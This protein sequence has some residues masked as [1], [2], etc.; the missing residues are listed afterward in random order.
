MAVWAIGAD[1]TGVI[2]T[3]HSFDFSNNEKPVLNKSGEPQGF[4]FWGEKCDG[5]IEGLVPTTSPFS[6]KI[7]SALTLANAMPAHLQASTGT[8]IIKQISRAANN[9]DFEKITISTTHHPY[10]IVGS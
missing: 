10:V 4:T 5:K 7:A 2:I 8:T 3:D 6:G 9:E 1:Q